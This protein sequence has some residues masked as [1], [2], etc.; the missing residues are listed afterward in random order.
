MKQQQQQ[1]KEG[2]GFHIVLISAK[3]EEACCSFELTVACSDM[4]LPRAP[5]YA[6]TLFVAALKPLGG[7]WDNPGT[8]K[9]SWHLPVT[10]VVRSKA[11]AR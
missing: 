4:A 11:E 9:Q 3:E 5:R 6:G 2:E 1:Q 7:R 8:S 10:G